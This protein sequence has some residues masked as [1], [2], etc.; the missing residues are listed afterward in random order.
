MSLVYE[1]WNQLLSPVRECWSSLLYAGTPPSGES[2]KSIY[3]GIKVVA[4]FPSENMTF[5]LKDK[6]D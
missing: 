5:V 3:V 1:F 4:Y 6:N 2:E